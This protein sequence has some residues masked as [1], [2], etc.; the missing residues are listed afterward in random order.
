M[1]TVFI[2]PQ[3]STITA[4]RGD[5]ALQQSG[6]HQLML[7]DKIDIGTTITFSV[8]SEIVLLFV[9]GTQHTIRGNSLPVE[10]AEADFVNDSS[11]EGDE[12]TNALNE[13]DAIQ[14]LI[15]SGDD[16]I[17]LPEFDT[18]EAAYVDGEKTER[19]F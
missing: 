16:Q 2:T 5:V 13:I 8:D 4:I 1:K 19:Q 7:G 12:L 14:A 10:K 15:E 6:S 17:N 11:L 9:D 18:E 3:N